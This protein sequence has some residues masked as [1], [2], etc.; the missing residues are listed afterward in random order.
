[1]YPAI[2]SALVL[3]GLHDG[4]RW[5]VPIHR[6]PDGDNDAQLDPAWSCFLRVSHENSLS[7][8]FHRARVRAA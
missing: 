4:R 3:K 1:M 5:W 7:D 8:R 6:L 2:L